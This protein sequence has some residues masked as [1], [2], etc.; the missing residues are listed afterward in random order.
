MLISTTSALGVWA[1]V[2]RN[3][4]AARRYWGWEIAWLTYSVVNVL[5]VTYIAPGS[6]ELT[7]TPMADVGLLTVYLLIGT[8]VWAFLH[9]VFDMTAFMVS[10]ERWEGTIEYTFM[11]PI[12]LATMLFGSSIFSVVYA[13]IRALV[14]LSLASLF[15]DLDLTGANFVTAAIFLAVGSIGFLGFGIVAAT[16][17]LMYVERGPQMTIIVSATLLLVS[18]I[19]YPISVLPGWLQAISWV[20]PARYVLEG[21]RAG[22]LDG[23]S[24]TELWGTLGPLAL[25]SA[26]AVPLGVWIFSLAAKYAKKTGRLKRSG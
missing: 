20:S 15:F 10:W 16:L 3:F 4:R 7:G 13:G 14:V 17:P 19:Y 5:A 1:F 12:R 8:L 21:I 24:V 2:E 25:I 22:I 11:A 9:E 26:A 18:G 6:R 23:L